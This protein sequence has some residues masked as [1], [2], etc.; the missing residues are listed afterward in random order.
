MELLWTAINKLFRFT[1]KA[2]RLSS[3]EMDMVTR[4]QFQSKTVCI[5]HRANTLGKDVNPIPLP[6]YG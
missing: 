6:N 5:S 4:V 2:E 3:Q 1:P